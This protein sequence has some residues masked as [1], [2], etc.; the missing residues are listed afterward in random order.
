MPPTAVPVNPSALSISGGD[1]HAF[2]E[3]L[4]GLSESRLDLILH[5]PGGSPEAAEAIVT[6][7]RSKFEH[8]RVFV[9][10]MAMSAATM[11][12]CAADEVVMGKHSFI[13]PINPQIQ[14]QTALGMRLVP[15]QAIIDQFERAVLECQDPSKVR[16]WLPM[17]AQYGPDLLVTCQNASI[18]SRDLV[19]DWLQK[20][21]FKDDVLASQKAG[22]IAAWMADHNSFKTHGRPISRED[23]R[24]RGMV[25]RNLEDDQFLQD[26]ILSVYHATS[27]AFGS[28]PLVKIVENHLG[29]AFMENAPLPTMPMPFPFPI[30]PIRTQ[31]GD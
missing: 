30:P 14:L 7:L 15:A 4:Y 18:L 13:G 3:A 19:S 26:A 12:A 28:L 8:I 1:L 5:S 25:I 2:M 9:P 27:I 31:S 17:L 23:A 20:Y 24:S 21:M 16:A 10:H 6:Y 22:D 11:I 29:K